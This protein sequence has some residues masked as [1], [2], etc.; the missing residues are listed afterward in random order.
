MP[1]DAKKKQAQKK[2]EQAKA[3]QQGKKPT[4]PSAKPDVDEKESSPV[5]NNGTGE[6]SGQNGVE[7]S[8]EGPYLLILSANHLS[9][10]G[11]SC[12]IWCPLSGTC[13]REILFQEGAGIR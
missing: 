13:P 3:R 10:L 7:L 4:N 11:Q 9:E 5:S 6:G 1:S 12:S 2:K 8:A